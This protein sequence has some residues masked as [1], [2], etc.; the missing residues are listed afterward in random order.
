MKTDWWKVENMVTK[1]EAMLLLLYRVS[2]GQ[3]K[4]VLCSSREKSR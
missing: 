3:R 4:A 1:D 2:N